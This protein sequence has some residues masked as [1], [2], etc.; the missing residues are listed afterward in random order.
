M[1]SIGSSVRRIRLQACKTQS[2]SRMKHP[3]MSRAS[4]F[5]DLICAT[6]GPLTAA[7]TSTPV[8]KSLRCYERVVDRTVPRNAPT[9]LEVVLNTVV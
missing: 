7:K 1:F 4:L 8:Y 2:Q 9:F 6:L 5:I 3:R